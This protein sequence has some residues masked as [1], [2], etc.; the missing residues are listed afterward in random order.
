MLIYPLFEASASVEYS[1]IPTD[2][3]LTIALLIASQTDPTKK[4]SKAEAKSA[5]MFPQI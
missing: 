5:Q 3:A 1:G 4:T 2:S